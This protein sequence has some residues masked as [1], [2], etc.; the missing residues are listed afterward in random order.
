MSQYHS[1]D[2]DW[3]AHF[4]HM[5]LTKDMWPM[6]NACNN[7]L[8]LALHYWTSYW[9]NNPIPFTS[10]QVSV[11]IK[12]RL[13]KCT[14][15]YHFQIGL[16]VHLCFPSLTHHDKRT[17]T[18]SVGKHL[19]LR[20]SRCYTEEHTGTQPKIFGA[21]VL[22]LT[23]CQIAIVFLLTFSWIQAEDAI[24]MKRL[25]LKLVHNCTMWGDKSKNEGA[26]SAFYTYF[27]LPN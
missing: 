8:R 26:L 10:Y 5:G 2:S 16:S 9:M 12:Q 24:K 13:T 23:Q 6:T 15:N 21:L 3:V 27:D 25:I 4:G 7:Q 14:V 18:L 1:H 17:H 20:Q 19:T 22:L 11:T